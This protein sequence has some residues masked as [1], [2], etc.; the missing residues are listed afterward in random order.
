MISCGTA[1]S[2]LRDHLNRALAENLMLFSVGGVAAILAQAASN[3]SARIHER[4][5]NRAHGLKL[6]VRENAWRGIAQFEFDPPHLNRVIPSS[7]T[8]IETEPAITFPGMRQTC[9]CVDDR[10]A[11]RRPASACCY[12]GA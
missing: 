6:L 9:F 11:D 4:R 7:L 8:F 10:Q 1:S 2:S 12:S 3:A 5:F